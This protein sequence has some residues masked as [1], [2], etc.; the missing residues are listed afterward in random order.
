MLGCFFRDP[1]GWGDSKQPVPLDLHPITFQDRSPS[2]ERSYGLGP[3]VEAMPAL[4]R[5]QPFEF[6]TIWMVRS[7]KLLLS[8]QQGRIRDTAV[9]PKIDGELAQVHYHR[10][11]QGGM[12]I[13]VERWVGQVG[14]DWLTAVKLDEVGTGD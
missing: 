14:D 12:S 9:V 5:R 2:V 8:V 7:E 4:G 3:V 13:R 10:G 11:S 6:S 1:G